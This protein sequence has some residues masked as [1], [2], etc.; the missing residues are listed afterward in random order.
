MCK[1]SGLV[2]K[3][4]YNTCAPN[5]PLFIWASIFASFVLKVYVKLN[6]FFS[7]DRVG[8]YLLLL[9]GF[10]CYPGLLHYRDFPYFLSY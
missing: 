3:V 2:H 1:L 9:L 8:K 5:L 7:L 4:C 6:T 10:Y